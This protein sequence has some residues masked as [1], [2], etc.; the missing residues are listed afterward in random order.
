MNQEEWNEETK[1]YYDNA[2]FITTPKTKADPEITKDL[3]PTTM[4]IIRQIQKSNSGR[5][6][7]VLFDSGS[8]KTMINQAALPKGYNPQVINQPSTNKTIEGIFATG[9]V[10]QLESI[11]LP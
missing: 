9:Q 8:G 5:L 10:V 6:L 1:G 4:M 11:L 3:V 7:R 2:F